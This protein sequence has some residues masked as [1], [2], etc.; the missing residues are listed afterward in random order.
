MSEKQFEIISA[1]DLIGS[2]VYP[3]ARQGVA[4]HINR[5]LNERG[6]RVRGL[7]NLEWF[8]Q[9]SKGDTH[10]ALLIGER[11]IQDE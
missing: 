3:G 11:T 6:K 4:E 1:L 7:R 10:E 8:E 9:P 5:I 2:S